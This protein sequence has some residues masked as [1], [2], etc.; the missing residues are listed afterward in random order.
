MTALSPLTRRRLDAFKRNRRGLW[1]LWLFLAVFVVT[2]FAEFVAND[3][4][5][6]V[7]YRGELYFPVVADYPRR[8]L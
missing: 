5:I 4:P 7:S 1:S 3:R 6:L 2:L 8:A